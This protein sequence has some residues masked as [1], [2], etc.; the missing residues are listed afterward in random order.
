MFKYSPEE[1]SWN[2]W[3]STIFVVHSSAIAFSEID[4]D[5]KLISC[6]NPM[7]WSWSKGDFFL[8][9]VAIIRVK[10]NH[11][12]SE[13]Q[14]YDHFLTLLSCHISHFFESEN[15]MY[16]I[17]TNMKNLACSGCENI[18][19]FSC[20]NLLLLS[21]LENSL[22]EAGSLFD[23]LVFFLNGWAESEWEFLII[24]IVKSLQFYFF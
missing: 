24:K 5:F 9:E 17:R 19:E 14:S 15:E 10:F 23:Y 21:S 7:I 22:R 12:S 16:K 4:E 18:L 6:F 11:I 1:A 13:I 2:N 20:L 3:I 8:L